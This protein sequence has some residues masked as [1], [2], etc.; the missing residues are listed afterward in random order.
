MRK[1]LKLL[2]CLAV[3][4]SLLFPVPAI[5][6]PAEDYKE[7]GL[8]YITAV[9]SFASYPGTD[10][11][12]AAA[13]MRRDGWLTIPYVEK[14]DT[15]Q[16]KLLLAWKEGQGV[17]TEYLLAIAGTH[18]IEG[19][20]L[21]FRAGKVYFAGSTIDEF[22]A[23]AD[24]KIDIPE[25]APMVH[26]GFHQY[27][28]TALITDVQP[29]SGE[30]PGRKLNELL[31]AHPDWSVY[32]TGHSAGGSA[33]T[34]LAARL[35]S[36]GVKPS[37]LKIVTFA[38]PAVGNAAF[39]AKYS[40]DLNLIR[41]VVA[42]DPIPVA[43]QRIAGGFRQFGREISWKIDGYTFDEKHYPYVY[44]DCAVKNYYDKRAAAARAGVPAA[45]EPAEKP[46]KDG[47]RLYIAA[48][49]N[50]LPNDLRGEFKY[51]REVLLD[52]YREAVPAYVIGKSDAKVPFH[53][54]ALRI[55]AQAAGCDRMAIVN[56]WGKTQDA[57]AHY[58]G[59][60]L[61]K[62]AEAYDLIVIEQTVFR[63]AD[64]ELL[65]GRTYEKGSKYFS[66]LGALLSAAV[67]LGGESAVWS[68]Q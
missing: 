68:G 18:N 16:V 17:P 48:I 27:V 6:G 45:S 29:P 61:T 60:L 9:A 31:L 22:A 49:H 67:A 13:I 39:N 54:E 23:N 7:A 10:G 30:A 66:A 24:K 1:M 51:M 63:V 3:E 42:G 41:V 25:Q 53:F 37:Q 57:P 32:L 19:M 33:A 4:V 15:A 43:L 40:P 8:L 62:A 2:I 65:D 55:K 11:D 64:G 34:L 58:S 50:N 46:A 44:L 14:D 59:G 26:K 52:Q 12:I 35:I 47:K 56:I 28:Q 21:V 20:K 36:M 38:A 5:A